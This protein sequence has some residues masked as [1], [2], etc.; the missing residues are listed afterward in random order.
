MAG[1]T[2]V[3]IVILAAGSS[4]RFRDG[5]KLLAKVLGR[6]LLRRVADAAVEAS[7]LLAD[8]GVAAPVVCVTGPHHMERRS[9][10]DGTGVVFVENPN[11]HEGQSSSIRA[12]LEGG[13]PGKK[14][15]PAK[16]LPGGQMPAGNWDGAA[17]LPGDLPFMRPSVIARAVGAFLD[18]GADRVVVPEVRQAAERGTEAAG[19]RMRGNPVV[20]P[21]RF[22]KELAALRGDL[23]GRHILSGLPENAILRLGFA[24]KHPFLDVDTSADLEAAVSRLGSDADFSDD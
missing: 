12:A 18:A 21:R 22:F 7:G 3:G 11:S 19:A 6:E 5:D 14:D 23:G 8:S 20:W 16:G 1:M 2:T 9:V 13:Q 15:G 17:F 10:L 24:E 4:K